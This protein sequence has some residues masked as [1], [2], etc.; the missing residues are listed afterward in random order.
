MHI[1]QY[2]IFFVEISFPLCVVIAILRILKF[3]QTHNKGVVLIYS[4][5][6]SKFVQKKNRKKCPEFIQKK[7]IKKREAKLHMLISSEYL[8]S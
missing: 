5:V 4:L 1:L 6:I 3:A 7:T 8:N 2:L